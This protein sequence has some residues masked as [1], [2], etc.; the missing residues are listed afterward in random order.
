MTEHVWEAVLTIYSFL[1]TLIKVEI[2]LLNL[3]DTFEQ[4]SEN[5]VS[6]ILDFHFASCYEISTKTIKFNQNKINQNWKQS[7]ILMALPVESTHKVC[8]CLNEAHWS[9]F[10]KRKSVK[11]STR[12]FFLNKLK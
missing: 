3:Q 7:V 9:I 2:F 6:L 11:E 4:T 12:R 1:L 5:Q 8:K 10:S